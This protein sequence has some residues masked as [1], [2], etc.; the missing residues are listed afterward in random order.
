MDKEHNVSTS[1]IVIIDVTRPID[2]RKSW[3]N[4][5]FCLIQNIHL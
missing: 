2:V 5:E 4:V 1:G 3:S